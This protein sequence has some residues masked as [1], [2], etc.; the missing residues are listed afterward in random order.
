MNSQQN[1]IE[2]VTRPVLDQ[3]PK[4]ECQFAGC[5]FKRADHG[6]VKEHEEDCDH[7]LVECGFCENKISLSMMI[8]HM[9][10]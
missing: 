7:R 4:A 6:F 3:L 2:L 1:R 5:N 8:D 9:A 10:R